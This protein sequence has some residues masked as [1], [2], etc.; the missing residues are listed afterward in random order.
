MR[1]AES[2]SGAVRGRGFRNNHGAGKEKTKVSPQALGDA[3][4]KYVGLPFDWKFDAGD[5]SKVYCSE[6]LY[7]A[8][9]DAAP[10]YAIA[11]EKVGG[12]AVIPVDAFLSP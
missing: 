9:G 2:R 10:G 6:L 4:G 11:A 7:R 5:P 8:Y 12:R 1:I 3:V